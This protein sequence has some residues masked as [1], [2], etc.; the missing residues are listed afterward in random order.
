MVRIMILPCDVKLLDASE[1]GS[2]IMC[3][4]SARDATSAAAQR[5]DC[6]GQ[7]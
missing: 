6:L 7:K 4:V 3:C 1:Q 5:L 2:G